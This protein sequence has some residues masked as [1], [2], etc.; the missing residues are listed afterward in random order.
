[1]SRRLVLL[2][3]F[4]Q[5]ASAMDTAG[6]EANA[7][8]IPFDPRKPFDP[9]GVRIGTPALTARGLGTDEMK[10]L[11]GWI[12]AAISGRDEPLPPRPH[13]AKQ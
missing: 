12:A 10:L 8:S 4:T 7:N 9:S 13:A 2:H 5:A 11:G 3:G 6:L 1:M